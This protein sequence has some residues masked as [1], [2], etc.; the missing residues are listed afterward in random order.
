MRGARVPPAFLS[1][2]F[3]TRIDPSIKPSASVEVGAEAIIRGQLSAQW[4]IFRVKKKIPA[5]GR[6]RIRVSFFAKSLFVPLQPVARNIHPLRRIFDCFTDHPCLSAALLEY[7]QDRTHA[8]F[9]DN[10]TEPH[11]HVIDLEHFGGPD[12]PI[13]LN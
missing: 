12:V 4:A 5:Q 1:R 7:R 11:T 3:H 13:F 2:G 9:S 8:W 10:D 6:V